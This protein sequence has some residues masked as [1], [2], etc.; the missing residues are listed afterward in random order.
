M[1]HG[2][3][4]CPSHRIRESELDDRVQQYAEELY[5]ELLAEQAELKRIKRLREQK[6]PAINATLCQLRQ[7]V[8]MLED[9]IE[10]LLLLRIQA[11]K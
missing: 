4:F 7:E 1:H 11:D 9:E 3:E 2:K 8:Q 5:R 10:N 6:S